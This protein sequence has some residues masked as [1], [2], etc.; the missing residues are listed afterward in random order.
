MFYLSSG[1]KGPHLDFSKFFSGLTICRIVFDG[2]YFWQRK[3]ISLLFQLIIFMWRWWQFPPVWLISCLFMISRLRHLRNSF[4][5]YF[6]LFSF[7]TFFWAHKLPHNMLTEYI[8]K[9]VFRKFFYTFSYWQGFF[10]PICEFCF[11]F[12]KL[13]SHDFYSDS[14]T[15]Y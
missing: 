9:T 8:E 10:H 11:F 1:Y 14:R 15:M 3:T 6:T 5:L 13:Q 2:I 4:A 12:I 7:P